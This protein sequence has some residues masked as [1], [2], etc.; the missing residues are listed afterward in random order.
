MTELRPA[1]R[2]TEIVD[3]AQRGRTLLSDKVIESTAVIAAGEVE[4]VVDARRVVRRSLPSAAVVV[5]N[6]E[7]RISVDVASTWPMPLS[8]VAQQVRSHVHDRVQALTGLPVAAV[9]VTVAA[10]VE[11]EPEVRVR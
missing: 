3:P 8:H 11:P 2:G 4:A 5:R 6:A 1:D 9:D 7:S 10:L